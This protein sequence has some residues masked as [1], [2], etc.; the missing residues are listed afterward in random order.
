M[1]QMKKDRNLF[2]GI[3]V[4]LLFASYGFIRFIY[5]ILKTIWGLL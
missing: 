2:F 3:V 4:V 1:E 5:I